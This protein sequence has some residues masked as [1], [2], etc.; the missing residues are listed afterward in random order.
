MNEVRAT[1]VKLLYGFWGSWETP[2][3][4]Y[5]VCQEPRETFDTYQQEQR[6][7]LKQLKEK[8]ETKLKKTM[9]ECF[10]N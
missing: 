8:L 10:L 4:S 2:F 6:D 3:C 5:D 7:Q 1:K 9:N